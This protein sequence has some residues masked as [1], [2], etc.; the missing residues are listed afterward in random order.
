AL[1]KMFEH[2][3]QHDPSDLD[4]ARE[5]AENTD[6]IRLGLFYQNEDRPRYEETRHLPH[7]SAEDKIA[8]LG[9]EFDRYAV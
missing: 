9:K 4:E 5:L 1:D 6:R 2:Q 7:H 8:L 3:V